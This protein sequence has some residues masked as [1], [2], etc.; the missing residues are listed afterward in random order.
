[1]IVFNEY[2]IVRDIN[3]KSVTGLD[4]TCHPGSDDDMA[5][6]EERNSTE[7]ICPMHALCSCNVSTELTCS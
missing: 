6:A 4:L 5:A 1:M 7:F 3:E 2:E